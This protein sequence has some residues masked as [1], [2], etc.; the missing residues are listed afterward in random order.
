M[1]APQLLVHHQSFGSPS[2]NMEDVHPKGVV[3]RANQTAR[4]II[5]SFVFGDGM[6]NKEGR[7]L[8][9]GVI[10]ASSQAGGMQEDVHPIQRDAEC[11]AI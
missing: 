4:L 11:N 10:L 7:F 1:L 9:A 8:K 3:N 2:E 6:V 5:E